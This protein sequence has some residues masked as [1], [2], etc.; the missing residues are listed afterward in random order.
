MDIYLGQKSQGNWQRVDPQIASTQSGPDQKG[1]DIGTTKPS[2]GIYVQFDRDGNPKDL[3]IAQAHFVDPGSGI[4]QISKGLGRASRSSLLAMIAQYYTKAA[5]DFRAGIFSRSSSPPSVIKEAITLPVRSARGLY[6]WFDFNKKKWMFY[7]HTGVTGSLVARKLYNLS[8]YLEK[9]AARIITYRSEIF[10]FKMAGPDLIQ[11]TAIDSDTG[12]QVGEP[13][14]MPMGKLPERIQSTIY[15]KTVKS[16]DSNLLIKRR[17]EEK[18]KPAEE[19]RIKIVSPVKKSEKERRVSVIYVVLS[20]KV[21]QPPF[22]GFRLTPTTDDN[23]AAHKEPESATFQVLE[24]YEIE[25]GPS[26]TITGSGGLKP[27]CLP[28]PWRSAQFPSATINETDRWYNNHPIIKNMT[29]QMPLTST[30]TITQMVEG[31]LR[32]IRSSRMLS[33]GTGSSDYLNFESNGGTFRDGR[34]AAAIG[35]G[36]GMGVGAVGMTVG[37]AGAGTAISTLSGLFGGAAVLTG[38]VVVAA[39]AAG[40]T[41]QYLFNLQ[42]AKTDQK[43]IEY[44]LESVQNHLSENAP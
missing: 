7:S 18:S 25:M 2:S 12:N 27:Y 28:G 24:R 32:P 31:R 38:G 15:K 8:S 10:Y 9:A 17:E 35:L 21:Q 39:I 5:N 26:G 41:F 16:D 6:L 40:A 11:V 33:Y 36:V 29:M 43:R 3:L 42:D 34:M 44:L 13:L 30:Q 20:P 19:A 1:M 23:T 14:H 37:T 4:T 22:I